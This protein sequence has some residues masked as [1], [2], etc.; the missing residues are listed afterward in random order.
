MHK[1]DLIDMNRRQPLKVDSLWSAL[2]RHHKVLKAGSG[3]P[4]IKALKEK[5]ICKRIACAGNKQLKH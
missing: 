5:K 3:S 2:M 4:R 1:T